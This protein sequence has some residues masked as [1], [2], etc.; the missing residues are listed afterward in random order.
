MRRLHLTLLFGVLFVFAWSGWKPYD[1]LTWWLE[2]IPGIVGL[3]DTDRDL[4]AFSFTT[5]CYTLIALHIVSS[6]S[7]GITP[8]RAYQCSMVTRDIP[9]A[10]QSLRSARTFRAGLRPGS[11]RARDFLR[12]EVV[13]LARLDAIRHRFRL[14]RES[15]RF[16]NCSNGGPPRSAAV[17][18][19]SS[20]RPKATYG[21]RRRICCMAL[22]A[23][24]VR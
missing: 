6:A 22:S 24:Y 23:R 16:T 9:L 2:T 5:L 1:R 11:D 21:T 18:R 3:I 10:P 20:S 4:S 7:A 13:Q 19:P 12:R 15:A 17:P 8:M 14:S